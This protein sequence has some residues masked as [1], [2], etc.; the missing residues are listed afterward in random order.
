MRPQ[1]VEMLRFTQRRK[2]LRSPSRRRSARSELRSTGGQAKAYP[3]SDEALTQQ[4]SAS[5]L[6]ALLSFAERNAASQAGPF[7][8]S[9][10]FACAF[11][12]RPVNSCRASFGNAAA[13]IIAALSVDK[14]GEGKYTG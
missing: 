8:A 5:C 12:S 7:Y 3:T 2:C 6:A 11:T 10:K 14:P 9:V 1:K 13:A 4:L